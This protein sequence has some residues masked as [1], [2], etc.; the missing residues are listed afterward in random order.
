MSDLDKAIKILIIDDSKL[1]RVTTTAIFEHVGFENIDTADGGKSALEK[2]EAEQY[3]LIV[4]DWI[5]PEMTGLEFLQTAK[6]IENYKEVP[7]IVA[8]AE[9]VEENITEAK[10]A[11]AV[12]YLTKPYS[13]EILLEKLNSVFGVE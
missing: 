4:L 3:Q 7:V 13:P 6:G 1:M 12:D 9:N 10:A 2:M 11:G 5:M 8:S